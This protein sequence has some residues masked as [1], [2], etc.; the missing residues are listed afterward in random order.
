MDKELLS[1]IVKSYGK[2]LD[3]IKLLRTD[4]QAFKE[5]F[6]LE[7][8]QKPSILTVATS[9]AKKNTKSKSEKLNIETAKVKSK[10]I[11]LK[12]KKQDIAPSIHSKKPSKDKTLLTDNIAKMATT[13]NLSSQTMQSNTKDIKTKLKNAVKVSV[14]DKKTEKNAKVQPGTLKE[15]VYVVKNTTLLSK[16]PKRGTQKLKTAIDAKYNTKKENVGPETKKP[17]KPKNTRLKNQSCFASSIL[18]KSAEPMLAQKLHAIQKTKRGLIG[19]KQ[20]SMQDN[21]YITKKAKPTL[22]PLDA[23]NGYRTPHVSTTI[24]S[25]NDFFASLQNQDN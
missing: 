13:S 22:P 25:Q 7:E 6:K 17:K 1:C 15:R 4:V 11:Y 2:L 24:N 9:H 10:V 23:N 19:K 16:G 21:C 8:N 20:K 3:E 12:N 14:N 18:D 5:E